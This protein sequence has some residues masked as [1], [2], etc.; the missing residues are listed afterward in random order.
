MSILLCAKDR[1]KHLCVLAKYSTL[2]LH[3]QLGFT[4]VPS[5]DDILFPSVFS[6]MVNSPPRQ[7]V[8]LN[9]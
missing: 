9:I 2:E 1:I 3:S 6:F 4:I 7:L 8:S 5:K